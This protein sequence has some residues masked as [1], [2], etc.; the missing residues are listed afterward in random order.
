LKILFLDHYGVMNLAGPGFIRT[1]DGKPTADELHG[2]A[3]F[4]PFDPG[5]VDVLN[6]VLDTTGAEIVVSSDWK[7]SATLESMSVFYQLQNIKKPPIDFTPWLPG[8]PTY[9]QQRAMEIKRWL[10][11]HPEVTHWVA[12]D[13]LHMG[14]VANNI[15]RAWGLR[16][17]VW[18]ENIQMGIKDPNIVNSMMTYLVC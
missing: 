15:E 9:H 6:R 4:E 5:A 3:M 13:D 1:W 14:V 7:R 18:T 2:R 16:N 11:D 12:V 10:A 17:F 8:H